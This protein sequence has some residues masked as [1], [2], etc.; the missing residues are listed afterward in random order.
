MQH[1]IHARK[2]EEVGGAR[3]SVGS[4][5]GAL[6][7]A[8]G[9]AAAAGV[10]TQATPGL[11]RDRIQ[12]GS[13]ESQQRR[14]ERTTRLGET[15]VGR[16][17]SALTRCCGC[18][19]QSGV[20]ARTLRERERQC[21][22]RQRDLLHEPGRSREDLMRRH[23]RR[24]RCRVGRCIRSRTCG[25]CRVLHAVVHRWRARHVVRSRRPARRHHSVHRRRHR[26]ELMQQADIVRGGH[27]GHRRHRCVRCDRRRLVRRERRGLVQMRHQMHRMR[28]AAILHRRTRRRQRDSVA[29]ERGHRG[30]HGAGRRRRDRRARNQRMRIAKV[31]FERSVP[32]SVST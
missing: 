31:R 30:G 24:R 4:Q 10:Q 17:L 12:T 14:G 26:V 13:G 8:A 27:R 28:I 22:L 32:N 20:Y 25:R 1:R 9:G 6:R 15:V 23:G 7:H 19:E 5:D 29:D 11:H 16:I 21:G 2:R 18:G 3:P